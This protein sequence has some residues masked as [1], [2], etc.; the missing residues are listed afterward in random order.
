MLYYAVIFFLIA[1]VAA[2]CGFGGVAAGSASV[3]RILFFAFA[4]LACVSL[5]AGVFRRD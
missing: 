3:A 4:M 5:I 1:L 2:L